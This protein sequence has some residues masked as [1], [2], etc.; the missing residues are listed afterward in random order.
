M[1]W[2]KSLSPPAELIP[3]L[4]WLWLMLQSLCPK[5][6]EMFREKQPGCVWE[7]T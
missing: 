4:T 2:G 7:E 1:G 6:G 3:V 5:T